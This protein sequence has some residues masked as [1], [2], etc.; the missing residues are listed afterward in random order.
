MSV[1]DRTCA[2]SLS[3]MAIERKYRFPGLTSR[4]RVSIV[5]LDSRHVRILGRGH[6]ISFERSTTATFARSTTSRCK[7]RPVKSSD[8]SDPTV[9]VRQRWCGSS[10]PSSRRRGQRDRR[11]LRR[12]EAAQPGT[13]HH[14][15]RGTVRDRGR[16]PHGL[17]ELTDGRTSQPPGT[18]PTSSRK[19]RQLL[20]DFGLADARTTELPRPTPAGCGAASTSRRRSSRIRRSSFSTS[21]RPAS[22]RR[23]AR[24]CGRSSRDLV[25]SGTTVLLTT[26]YLEEADRLAQTAG[27]ARSRQDHR[28]GNVGA[29]EGAAGNTVLVLTILPHDRATRSVARAPRLGPF[30]EARQRRRHRASS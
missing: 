23:A 21:R 26:Q 10:P 4:R 16:K 19:S 7:C 18:S 3:D 28:R 1:A 22:T 13:S 20:D 11:R 5:C 17:R 25:E 12:R 27:R 24:T 9:R 8:S 6:T 2:I 30:A 14:R 29:A 15:S